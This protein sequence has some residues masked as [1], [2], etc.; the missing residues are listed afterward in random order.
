VENSKQ[1]MTEKETH[2][3][4]GLALSTLR[5]HRCRGIGLPYIKVGRA[6]RYSL[7]DVMAFME[8]H[9]IQTDDPGH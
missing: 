3:I 8:A 7:A 6:V 9:K 1:Y 5:N 4:T 2:N